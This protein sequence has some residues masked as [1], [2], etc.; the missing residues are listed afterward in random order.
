MIDAR[1]RQ[2]L[3]VARLLAALL[4]EETRVA[5]VWLFGS[6]ALYLRILLCVVATCSCEARIWYPFG[7]C[8]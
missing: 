5:R 4:V 3:S 8:P 2:A 1:A 7:S 6:L